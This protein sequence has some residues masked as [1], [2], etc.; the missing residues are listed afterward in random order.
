[1]MNIIKRWK[2]KKTRKSTNAS[3]DYF[4]RAN[5][6]DVKHYTKPPTKKTPNAEIVIIHTGTNKLL[7]YINGHCDF[8]IFEIIPR[9]IQL[10]KKAL[11]V[12][13]E[14]K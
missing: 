2:I 14:L 5:I 11:N 12:N 9:S 13:K 3:I 10:Q 1:M 4:P 8:I 7:L 6:S